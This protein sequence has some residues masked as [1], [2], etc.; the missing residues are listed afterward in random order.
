MPTLLRI[1]EPI[2]G[3]I[4]NWRQGKK[5]EEGLLISVCG[6]DCTLKVGHLC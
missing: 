2:N 3:A 4:I 1:E 6:L 5:T